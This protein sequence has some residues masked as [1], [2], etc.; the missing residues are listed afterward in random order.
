MSGVAGAVENLAVDG[1]FVFGIASAIEVSLEDVGAG[2]E[3]FVFD[4]AE[5][6]FGDGFSGGKAVARG[7]FFL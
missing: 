5:V 3:D 2:D 4:D 6:D 1:G 7:D